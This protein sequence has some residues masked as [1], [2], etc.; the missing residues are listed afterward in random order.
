M[1]INYQWLACWFYLQ[2]KVAT[3]IDHCEGTLMGELEGME[4]R[5]L[6]IAKEFAGKLEDRYLKEN[7]FS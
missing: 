3:K 4:T 6:D 2:E 1:S 5:R 7:V